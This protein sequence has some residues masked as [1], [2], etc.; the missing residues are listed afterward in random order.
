MQRDW[1]WLL[2]HLG[3][4]ADYLVGVRPP[5]DVIAKDIKGVEELQ[6]MLRVGADDSTLDPFNRVAYVV[7]GSRVDAN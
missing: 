4:V 5:K 1:S 3:Q 6:V 2:L 7:H